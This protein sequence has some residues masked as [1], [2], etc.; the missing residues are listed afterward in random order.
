MTDAL[1]EERRHLAQ[2]LEA[3]QRCA[4]FLDHS[5]KKIDWPWPCATRLC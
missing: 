3:L 2:L 1:A 4:Y 5:E